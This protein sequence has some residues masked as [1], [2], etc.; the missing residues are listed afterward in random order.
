MWFLSWHHSAEGLCVR[1]QHHMRKKC[2]LCNLSC[3][4]R[5]ILERLNTLCGSS[6][7]ADAF[8]VIHK[9]SLGNKKTASKFKPGDKPETLVLDRGVRL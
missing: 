3:N 4:L 2:F 7:V 8:S 5:H 9:S 1:P 6:E